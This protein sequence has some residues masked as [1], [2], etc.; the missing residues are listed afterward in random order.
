MDNEFIIIEQHDNQKETSTLF[1]IEPIGIGTGYCE[2]LT[3]YLVR[4]SEAHC[5]KVG[6]LLNRIVGPALMKNYVIQSA[7][8][9]GNRFYDGAKALNGID[10]NSLDLVIAIE[11]L[12]LREDL[13]NLTLK[14]WEQVFTN[15]AL[16]KD[17][18]NWCPSC[19]KEFD[20]QYGFKYFPLLW[21]IKPVQHCLKHHIKLID[22]CQH[23]KRKIPILNRSSVNGI[24]SYCRGDLAV[25]I[26]QNFKETI[27]KK[28][29]FIV[30][31]ISDLIVISENLNYKLDRDILYKKITYVSE[32]YLNRFER[33]LMKDL[34][35]PKTTFN[36]WLKGN[37]IPTLENL[38]N[39]CF[40]TDISLKDFL[41]KEDFKPS[42]V[43]IKNSTNSPVK[44]N[45][46]INYLKIEET[47]KSFQ[48]GDEPISME[49]ISRRME[50][51]KRTLYRNF[52]DLCKSLAERFLNEQR[53][54]SDNRKKHVQELIDQ[55]VGE[56]LYLGKLPTQKNI[57]RHL[58]ANSLLRESF[59][60][61]Y[62]K[63]LINNLS[64]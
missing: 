41:F 19:L 21:Y 34:D 27:S 37:S 28:D 56:L 3:S 59:A 43:N 60:K 26:S 44:K 11:T 40:S 23:C 57:E 48:A 10:K 14:K 6:I 31:N 9:G 35:I 25:P 15:R 13:I 33:I 47:L 55:S 8:F 12:T 54:K 39:I 38:L 18:L 2:S 63:N 20:K 7:I 46:K 4:L 61:E 36:Y 1:N 45:Q 52:P 32:N 24:C 50:V 29:R 22:V 5:I 16:L 64:D 53:L 49:A 17:S 58:S 51:S 62:L 30:Q 42:I